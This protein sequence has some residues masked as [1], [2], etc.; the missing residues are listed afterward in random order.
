MILRGTQHQRNAVTRGPGRLRANQ[1]AGSQS[2]R[3]PALP[4]PAGRPGKIFRKCT[5][6]G[7]ASRAPRVKYSNS[8]ISVHIN[9]FESVSS[10]DRADPSEESP[11]N[12]MSSTSTPHNEALAPAQARLAP[13]EQEVLRHIAAGH[14]YA[15]T[16]RRMGLSQHTVDAYLRRIRAKLGINSTAELMRLAI[17]LGL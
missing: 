13:R 4:A 14:T 7:T 12:P 6:R 16:A 8:D 2:A 3:C 11:S 17:S 5:R 15:Q 1:A 9:R 10:D